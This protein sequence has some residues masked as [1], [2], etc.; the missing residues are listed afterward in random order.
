MF[1]TKD[2]LDDS[3]AEELELDVRSECEKFGKVE[4]IKLF[5]VLQ[6]KHPH[7]IRIVQKELYWWCL[8]IICLPNVAWRYEWLLV[9]TQSSH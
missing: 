6:A 3:A 7:I 4:E 9:L 5:R 2:V 8:K 1:D